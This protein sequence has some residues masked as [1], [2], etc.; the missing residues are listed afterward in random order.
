MKT[1]KQFVVGFMLGALLMGVPA[2]WALV[3]ESFGALDGSEA[4]PAFYFHND[5]DNGLYRRAANEWS[6]AAGGAEIVR[7]QTTGISLIPTNAFLRFGDGT[8]AAP[9]IGFTSDTNTGIYLVAADRLGFTTGGVAVI[10]L[11]A[12][13]DMLWATDN[14]DDIGAV[15]A[16][17]PRDLFLGRNAVIGGTLNAVGATTLDGAVTLGNAA[18]DLVVVAGTINSNVIFTDASFDIGAAGAT[19][20][21]AL[22]LSGNATVGAIL[23]VVGATTLDGAVTLGN[24]AAD[25]IT[26]TGS[27]ASNL[28]F[29]ED[30]ARTI[31]PAD[32]ATAATAGDAL[33]IQAG[34]GNTTGNGGA[35]AAVGGAGGAGATGATGGAASL[36]GGAGGT[37][38]ATAGGA[39]SVVGGASGGLTGD[40]AD[41]GAANLTG[42]AGAAVADSDGGQVNITGGAAT[43]GAGTE[44]GGDVV[45]RGGAGGE[46]NG[47]I[48]LGDS[49][50]AGIVVGGTTGVALV[51]RIEVYTLTNVDLDTTDNSVAA[52]VCEAQAVTVTGVAANDSLVI[53]LTSAD[54]PLTFTV[55]HGI[56]TADTVTFRV[57]NET[58]GGLDPGATADFRVLAISAGTANL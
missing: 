37:A 33:T 48:V 44:D 24:A 1:L 26:V 43:A 21:R 40:A 28:I 8:A 10:E 49:N 25:N 32:Q 55:P 53:T 16:S 23:N 7:I 31:R 12:S 27:L 29:A 9:T 18:A 22:F 3:Q 6:L 41:G 20:P 46:S 5:T 42:G 17:R 2:A 30:T 51:T 47:T 57:C 58:A 34:L 38:S 50:T 14:I 19:R 54:L 11:D 36:T 15:A 45:I 35:F 4:G 13:G 39:A 52:N 56:P